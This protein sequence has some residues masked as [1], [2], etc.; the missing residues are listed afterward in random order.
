MTKT[1]LYTYTHRFNK[2]PIFNVCAPD[3]NTANAMLT[4]WAHNLPNYDGRNC[5]FDVKESI[6]PIVSKKESEIK[7]RQ[8]LSIERNF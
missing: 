5:D 7:I 6:I 8:A 3:R 2:Y 1:K 4:I